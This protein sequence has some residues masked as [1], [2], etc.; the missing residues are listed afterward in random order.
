MAST[1]AATGN[2]KPRVFQAVSTDPV[3]KTTAGR[4]RTTKTTTTKPAAKKTTTTGR[5]SKPKTVK[6]KPSVK[7]KVEGALK[8]AEGTVTNKPGKKAAGT[9]Q[10]KGTDGKSARGRKVKV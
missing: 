10:A 2:S 9:K 8:K 4:K 3:R 6:G 5:V 7:D 1:R